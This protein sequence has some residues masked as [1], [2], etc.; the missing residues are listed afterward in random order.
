LRLLHQAIVENLEV[1][2]T[3]KL[4]DAPRERRHAD[5]LADLIAEQRPD[6]ASVFL[7]TGLDPQ[8]FDCGQIA[9]GGGPRLDDALKFIGRNRQLRE[10]LQL[11]AGGFLADAHRL[12]VF[13][14]V[15]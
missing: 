11:A 1:S 12:L 3:I 8:E 4:I 13:G 14:E 9:T 2:L 5:G 6:G 15:E 7:G 10:A